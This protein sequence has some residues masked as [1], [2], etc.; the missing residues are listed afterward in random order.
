MGQEVSPAT[1][2]F[3]VPRLVKPV[4]PRV[5]WV[6]PAERC[7]RPAAALR[8]SQEAAFHPALGSTEQAAEAEAEVPTTVARTMAAT[9]EPP[10]TSQ[11][12]CLVSAPLPHQPRSWLAGPSLEAEAEARVVV[13]VLRPPT[14]ATEDS[15]VGVAVAQAERSVTILVMVVK[16]RTA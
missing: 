12:Q 9:G 15:T 10:T 6:G 3:L 16:E 5:G 4:L 2:P 14:V 1:E 13:T 7:P 11:V 8:L